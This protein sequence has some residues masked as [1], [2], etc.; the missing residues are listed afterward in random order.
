M[1]DNN[2][3][4][5][6]S[7]FLFLFTG[8]FVLL[9]V[10]IILREAMSRFENPLLTATLTLFFLSLWTAAGGMFFSRGEDREDEL[11]SKSFI[12][13]GA[14]IFL[15]P[16][17]LIS[18]LSAMFFPLPSSLIMSGLPSLLLCTAFSTLWIGLFCGLIM[19][20]VFSLKNNERIG[21]ELS[22]CIGL[23]IGGI[24]F[25]LLSSRLDSPPAVIALAGVMVIIPRHGTLQKPRVQSVAV[26]HGIV[27]TAA[28]RKRGICF[29]KTVSDILVQGK[30]RLEHGQ[31]PQHP[32]RQNNRTE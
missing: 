3:V 21:S 25:P 1:S 9:T 20:L 2:P 28:G 13:T 7:L 15:P 16:T 22:Y 12:L 4:K 19:A 11:E 5:Y 8:C 14:L 24:A 10:S 6:R 30:S 18:V 31:K 27:R 23:I 17:A 32:H 26:G 29:A